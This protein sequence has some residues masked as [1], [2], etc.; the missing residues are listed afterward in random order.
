LSKYIFCSLF[1]H[2]ESLGVDPESHG[3]IHS[4]GGIDPLQLGY[5]SRKFRCTDLDIVPLFH[6]NYMDII[7]GN[8][9]GIA[10][11]KVSGFHPVAFV[12]D[13]QIFARAFRIDDIGF[14]RIVLGLGF[15]PDL[16]AI[17]FALSFQD[18]VLTVFQL[19]LDITVSKVA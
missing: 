7:L 10:Y 6:G 15:G 11:D 12:L 18:L 16:D 2:L 4:F 9:R 19:G 3:D 5:G 1:H 8:R 13:V 17:L 14:Q